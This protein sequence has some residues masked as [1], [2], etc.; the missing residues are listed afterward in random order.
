MKQGP[1]QP[2]RAAVQAVLLYALNNGYLD[3]IEVS[4]VSEWQSSV[5]T[6]MNADTK[7]CEMIE[8]DWNE[9]V[10]NKVKEIL[11]NFADNK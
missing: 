4:K 5:S 1:F 10:E 6:F 8:K 2:V 11:S 3:K 7:T 9:E